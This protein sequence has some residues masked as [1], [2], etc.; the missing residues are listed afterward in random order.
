MKK[1][2]LQIDEWT[3]RR[4]GQLAAE[5]GLG[6]REYLAKVLKIGLKKYTKKVDAGKQLT[7]TLE[8]DDDTYETLECYSGCFYNE[9]AAAKCFVLSEVDREWGDRV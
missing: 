4:A 6:F 9:D 8:I 2:T 3:S 5:K 7:V 1:I